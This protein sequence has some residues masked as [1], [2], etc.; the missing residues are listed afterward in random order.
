MAWAKNGTPHTLSADGTALE[1]TDLGG[2]IFT[3]AMIHKIDVG[4]AALKEEWNN[5]TGSLYAWRRSDSG[6][7]DICFTSQADID[8][9]QTGAREDFAIKYF[10]WVS[11]EEKLSLSFWMNN[12]A[13]TG[14]ANAPQRCEGVA[15][16]VPSPLTDTFD[17][18]NF[19]DTGDYGTG[20]NLSALGTD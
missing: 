4:S 14:A 18:L 8:V 15:K 7:S 3:Q 13:A 16:Y 17:S 6:G 12:G 5:D 2:K 20:S 1:I 10:S 9:Y 11:G 19:A